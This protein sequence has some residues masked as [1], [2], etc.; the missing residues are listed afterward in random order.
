LI[1]METAHGT[2]FGKSASRKGAAFR[3]C[4]KTRPE[5]LKRKN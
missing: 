4:G 1:L 2:L 5:R 3:S